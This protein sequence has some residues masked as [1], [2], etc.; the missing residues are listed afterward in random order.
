MARLRALRRGAEAARRLPLAV[1]GA[2]RRFAEDPARGRAALERAWPATARGPRGTDPAA[3]V[4]RAVAEDRLV[5]AEIALGLLD[6][7]DSRRPSCEL[8]VRRLRGDL[9]DV[10]D[11]PVHDARGRR[12]AR[13]ARRQ[14]DELTSPLPTWAYARGDNAASPPGTPPARILHVVTNSLP[15]TQAGSTIRTHRILLAQREFGWDA[16]AAT[17]PGYP[18]TYGELDAAPTEF[19]DGVPYLRLLPAVMPSDAALPRAYVDLLARVADDFRPHLLHA[20]SDHVNARV[21]LEVGRRAGIPV[22]YEVRAFHEETWL[23]RHGGESARHSDVYR[24]TRERHTEVMRAADLVTTLGESMRAE[25]IA[26][27]VDADRVVVVPNGVPV[28]FL[29]GKRESVEARAD[30]GLD[31]DGFW[32]GSVATIHDAEGFEVM[33]DALARLRADGID[34]RALLVGDGPA[35]P[36]LRTRARDLAVPMT[37]PGRVPVTEVSR[38]FDALDVFAYPRL[39]TPLNREVTGLKP[40]EAQARGLPVVGTDLPAVAEVLAPQTPLVVAGDPGAL[41]QALRELRD[42]ARRRDLG[43][44]GKAWVAAHRTWPSVTGRYRTA[45]AALGVPTEGNPPSGPSP[46]GSAE[47]TLSG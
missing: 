2:L 25:I 3:L 20:A 39:D 13:T 27:G 36:R 44:R 8:A 30:L 24:W 11:H 38:Y 14:V 23:S 9:I 21:A 17:R 32:V 43:E 26:R 1:T 18:V 40:L 47:P 15:L 33:L 7:D 12:V 37:T 6:A 16:R 41:A 46:G 31:R 34:A 19:L 5:D 4:D 45:Y 10:L 22:A 28:G 35:L 29:E 42:P